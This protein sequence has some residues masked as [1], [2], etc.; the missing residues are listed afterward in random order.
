MIMG[1]FR[2]PREIPHVEPS[3]IFHIGSFPV[4]NSTLMILF[5]IMI[6][7]LVSEFVIR[8][9]KAQPSKTQSIIEIL[10]E[11][12]LDLV[13]QITGSHEA[14][15][16][17]FPLV[18]AIFVYLGMANLIGVVPGLAEITVGPDI[19]LL[20]TPTTDFNTTFGL[21]LAMVLL[22]QI[23]SIK[24]IGLFLY[25]GKFL[26]FRQ[27]WL[28]FRKSMSEGFMA[29][30][31]F[32]IGLLEIISEVSK[33]ISLSLRLFGNMYAGTVL[34]AIALGAFAY[35]LPAVLLGVHLLVS[36]VQ[37]I[38]FGSLIT[39]YYALSI[40]HGEETGH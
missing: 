33:V 37:A 14:S 13:T 40:S 23:L 5:I 38:V 17:I 19:P 21:A 8:H 6:L 29:I 24:E 10:Y 25:L 34:A 9:F 1:F 4:A 11:G 12:M 18:G 28:G 20:R 35:V 7:A 39:A 3:V 30:I 27:V 2:F 15:A 32:F 16:K 36:V 26:Q 22:L 31:G